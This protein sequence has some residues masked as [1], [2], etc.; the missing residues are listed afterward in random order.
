MNMAESPIAIARN[1][2]GIS[3]AEL[4]R[5][6]GKSRVT[7]WNWE[8]RKSNPGPDALAQIADVLGVQPGDLIATAPGYRALPC[9]L[10]GKPLPRNHSR[11]CGPECA[12]SAANAQK[13]R[14]L[15]EHLEEFGEYNR[16]WHQARLAAMTPEE[17]AA[18]REQVNARARENYRKRH[19]KA[20]AE[21]GPK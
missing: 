16:R 21:P 7:I 18:H 8:H 14:Y 5:R 10:C 4:A 20:N 17:L 19:E 9:A 15:R 3:Q 2:A 6:V 1:R 11:Y 12:R 13:K